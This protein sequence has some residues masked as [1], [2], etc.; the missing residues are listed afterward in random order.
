MKTFALFEKEM[1]K[2]MHFKVQMCKKIWNEHVYQN[3]FL[4]QNKSVVN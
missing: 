2:E 3:V 1:K 4:L